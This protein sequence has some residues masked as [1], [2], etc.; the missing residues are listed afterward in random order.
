MTSK[1]PFS[2]VRCALIDDVHQIHELLEFYAAEQIVLSRTHEEIIDNV[3]NFV[4]AVNDNS[5][6]LGCVALRDFGAQ[7]F[8]VRSLVVKQDCIGKGIGKELVN[9][10]IDL[11]KKRNIAFRLFALTYKIDFF[12]KL[13]F[14]RVNME[15][16]PEKIWSDC[17]NC[18][19]KDHCDEAAVLLE[20]NLPA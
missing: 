9:F 17:V 19:K 13:G 8:E 18:P 11:L 5:E 3:G 15:M 12:L 16:F 7:L 10:V 2:T 6:V 14:I 4:V 20:H 1:P